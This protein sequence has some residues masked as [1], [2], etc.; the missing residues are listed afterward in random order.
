MNIAPSPDPSP[1]STPDT[2]SAA[3]ASRTNNSMGISFDDFLGAPSGNAPDGKQERGIAPNLPRKQPPEETDPALATLLP[4]LLAQAPPAPLPPPA[5]AGEAN[6]LGEVNPACSAPPDSAASAAV[7]LRTMPAVSFTP[8]EIHAVPNTPAA[9]VVPSEISRDNTAETCAP[10]QMPEEKMNPETSGPRAAAQI[11]G[12]KIPFTEPVRATGRELA[13]GSIEQRDFTASVPFDS[14][15]AAADSAPAMQP[16]QPVLQGK[17]APAEFSGAAVHLASF[18]ASPLAE[19]ASENGVAQMPPPRNADAISSPQGD[20]TTVAMQR[21]AMPEQIFERQFKTKANPAT[22]SIAPGESGAAVMREMREHPATARRIEAAPAAPAMPDT[23]SESAANNAHGTAAP[24]QTQDRSDAP[25]ATDF[26]AAVRITKQ[27]I[28]LA[29]HV[30]AMGRDHVEIQ[31]RLRDGQEVTVS[32][33]LEHGEWKPVF[34][35]DTAALCQALE[36]NWHRAAA[37]PSAQAVKFGTPVFESQG[38]QTDLGQNAQQQAGG[39]ERAFD[40]RE[41]ES[42]FG[43]AAPLPRKNAAAANPARPAATTAVQLYA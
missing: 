19:A 27:T 31:M 20:G 23:H 34:K 40:R 4:F 29:E 15:A 24:I 12:Q 35:T 22:V 8:R 11:A 21:R 28:D 3:T 43:T 9:V 33:R 13:G 5:P 18:A 36:Q 7:Q 30:R 42:A 10:I 32:L 17:N 26:T 37:Q 14:A 38:A 39:R 2:D 6:D 1:A 25:A 16:A 41:Q